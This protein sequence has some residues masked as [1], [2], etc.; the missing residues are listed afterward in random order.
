MTYRTKTYIAADW[1]GDK[2]AVDQLHTWND[3]GPTWLDVMQTHPG[4]PHRHSLEC[5]HP[6]LRRCSLW[7]L[8]PH[9][10]CIARP[11]LPPYVDTVGRNQKAIEAYI[12][13]QMQEDIIADQV[14]IK[15]YVDPF[16][17]EPVGKNKKK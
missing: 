7:A 15:E 6:R 8:L 14:S 2:S 12:K 5:P 17:G 16:T 13:N 1:T 9:I 10:Q 3:I 11:A 4:R